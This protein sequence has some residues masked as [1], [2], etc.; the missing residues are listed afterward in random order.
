MGDTANSAPPQI[1]LDTSVSTHLPEHHAH[2][3]P[4]TDDFLERVRATRAIIV[5][6]LTGNN[7][8]Q[9]RSEY[10][11]TSSDRHR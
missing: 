8:T 1:R 10:F 7:D 4:E 2:T 3:C 5:T 6:H 9:K 11:N